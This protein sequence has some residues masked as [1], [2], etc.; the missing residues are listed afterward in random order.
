MLVATVIAVYNRVESACV[1][2]LFSLY[3]SEKNLL[4]ITNNECACA[5]ACKLDSVASSGYGLR[6]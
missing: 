5:H 3:F 1:S 4:A 6:P 2:F